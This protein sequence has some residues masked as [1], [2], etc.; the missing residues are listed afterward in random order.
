MLYNT[1]KLGIFSADGSS[2]GGDCLG[3]VEDGF[4]V[5]SVSIQTDNR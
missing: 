5:A 1:H 4:D 2:G 3:E